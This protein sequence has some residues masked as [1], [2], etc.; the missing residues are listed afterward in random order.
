[1]ASTQNLLDLP[2][3]IFELI[4]DKYLESVPIKQAWH[5]REVC[6]TP[7]FTHP[8]LPHTDL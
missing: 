6:C 2:I 1:M 5:A 8:S 7:T 4:F 3:E